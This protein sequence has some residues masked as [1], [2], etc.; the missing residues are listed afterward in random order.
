MPKSGVYT[1]QIPVKLAEEIRERGFDLE[2]LVID[3][4]IEKLRMN[5]EEEAAAR[6]EI[7][8]H[9]LEE[10]RKYVEKGDSVQASEKLYKAAEESIKALASHFRVP[11]LDEVRKRRKW[12]TWLLGKAAT[13]LAEKLGEERVRVAWAL[14]YDVHVWGF[15]EARY[16]I[17]EV[18]HTLPYV[19]WLLQHAR[20]RLKGTQ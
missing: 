8:E 17:R 7:A 10:A 4:I 6:I 20:E 5:P 2:A 15:H 13:S 12:D 16:G 19:E 9:F 1:I 3:A 14:A 11:E 18:S